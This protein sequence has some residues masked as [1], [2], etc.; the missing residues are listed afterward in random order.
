MQST[1]CDFVARLA[2]VSLTRSPELLC[3]RICF[4][5]LE[6][7]WSMSVK[8]ISLAPKHQQGEIG[9]RSAWE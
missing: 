7:I 6:V 3:K 1:N 2:K 5:D 4:V 8:R 9:E